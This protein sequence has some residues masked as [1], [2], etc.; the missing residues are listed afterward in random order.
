MSYLPFDADLRPARERLPEG[1]CDCH[2][3]FFQEF[4]RFPVSSAAAYVPTPA[5]IEDYRRMCKAYGV[6]RGVLVHPSVYGADHS[7][8]EVFMAA[9]QD[10][11]RGVAVAP[12]NVDAASLERW[13]ALGTRGTR[14]NRAFANGPSDQDIDTIIDKIKPLGWHAQVFAPLLQEP[15][16][17]R[18]IADRGVS[19][20]V[21]HLG[22]APADALISSEP[23]KD[24]LALMREG[25]AW[26]K[27]SGPYRSSNQMP[28]YPDLRPVIDALLHAN[29]DR[30]VWGTDWPHPHIDAMP[31]DGDLVD[32]IFDWLPDPQLR[33]KILV[34][35][36]TRLYW[37]D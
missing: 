27:L 32:L 8:Y 18:R 16:L 21:D 1:A 6:D 13:H 3:H 12:A 7:S 33:Q 22:Y 2:F 37:S 24:L 30:A 17:I 19:V 26:L 15:G 14:I 34:D 25:Q 9:N 23:F 31:N 10:W 20:V 11:L 35:N 4:E 29:S 36:P 28:K 5:T